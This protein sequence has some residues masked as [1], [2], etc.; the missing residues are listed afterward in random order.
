MLLISSW[1]L[2]SALSAGIEELS[3]HSWLTDRNTHSSLQFASGSAGLNVSGLRDDDVLAGVVVCGAVALVL[4]L[5][6]GGLL[7]GLVE[8]GDNVGVEVLDF[9]L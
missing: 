2:H 5:L 6:D 7:V 4:G 1:K 8:V 9:L 3:S